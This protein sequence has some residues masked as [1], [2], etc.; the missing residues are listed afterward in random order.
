MIYEAEIWNMIREAGDLIV[1][2]KV[3]KSLIVQI[4]HLDSS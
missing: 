3:T 2:K 4:F 1:K